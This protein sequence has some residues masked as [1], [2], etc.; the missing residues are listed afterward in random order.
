[1]STSLSKGLPKAR[2]KWSFNPVT[3]PKKPGG[4]NELRAVRPVVG[5]QKKKPVQKAGDGKAAAKKAGKKSKPAKTKDDGRPRSKGPGW[6]SR[7][8]LALI[9]IGAIGMIVGI[10][11]VIAIVLYFSQDLPD[12]K[13]LAEY[14]PPIVTRAYA[15]DGRLLAEFASEKRVFINIESVPDRVVQAFLSAEDKNFYEHPGIDVTGIARAVRDNLRN[16]GSDRRLV[17]A[18]TITQQV[19]KNFLLSD[20]LDEER[21]DTAQ[22]VKRKIRE[23]IL[24]F[25]IEEALSKDKILELYLNEIFLGARAYGVAA[26]ALEYFNKPLKELSIEEAAFL[27]ALP[28]APNNYNPQRHYEAAVARRNWVI[29]QMLEN[30][31][32]TAEEAQTAQEKPLETIKRDSDDYVNSPY[33]AEEVRRRLKELYSDKGLYEGGMIAY[34]TMI[35]EY[36][37]VAERV[38]RNG[39]ID[40]DQRH[41]LH[42][43]A[44]AKIESLADWQAALGGIAPPPGIGNFEMAVVLET[45]AKEAKIGLRNGET[46]TV[47]FDRMKWARAKGKPAPAKVSDVLLTGDVWLF[48]NTGGKGDKAEWW[49]RQIPKVQGGIIAMDP[50]TGRIY[51]LAG[52]FSYD[53]NQFNRATQ[54]IRQPGSAFKPIVYLAGLQAGFTPA[55]LILDAPFEMEQGP[56]LD[57]WRPKNYSGDYF[58]PT[59]LRVGIEK[60]RNLMTIRLA[61]YAGM[62]KIAELCRAFGITDNLPHML[63]MAIGAGETTLL[64]MTSAYA[65][66]VNGGKR[67]TPTVID[68]VQDRTGKTVY[69]H[70]RRPCDGCGPMIP[71]KGQETPDVPD[72]R[73]Q[74]ADPR[75]MYQ[76]VSML[77]GVVQ[78]GTGSMIRDVGRPVAGKTGTTNDSKDAWFIGFTPDLVVGVYIGFDDPKSMGKKETGSRIAAPVFK[79]FI[80]DALKDA[81]PVPFRVPEGIRLVLIDP[82]TGTRATPMTEK[83]L[84]EAF[85]AGTEPGEEAMMFTGQGV[86]TISDVTSVGEGVNT[87]LGGLY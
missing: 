28:K 69:V 9:S 70:D 80:K 76:I 39:L 79:E 10:G 12:Y 33:F 17:G 48:E 32:I 6:V 29:S 5:G 58:G 71:W 77:E 44:I 85:I 74:V 4:D 65:I 59:T 34:S 2:S 55:T 53:M 51:A 35:P 15:S 87:G 49:L 72:M 60:S 75:H 66:F 19:A 8:F 84:L 13:S 23:M 67:I 14:Q 27:A 24:S 78:R 30:E 16:L 11:A 25:R 21:G 52:G 3:D 41:G 57:N 46:A 45:G 7:V 38:L 43:E 68:R 18:S 73:E 54:A 37:K 26:A 42:S 22:K 1:M 40:Y 81:P 63:S 20:G 62:E 47:I 50:H 36:Q 82:T 64:R 61:N 56:G 86:S 31:F 83:P